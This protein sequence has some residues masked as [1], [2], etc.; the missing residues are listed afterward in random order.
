MENTY[1]LQYRINLA[2]VYGTFVSCPLSCID[3]TEGAVNIELTA[4]HQD[5]R[6]MLRQGT[7]RFEVFGILAKAA[8]DTLLEPNPTATEH[9]LEAMGAAIKQRAGMTSRD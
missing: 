4:G 2:G 7:A 5:Y 8:C 6:D 9:S 1:R 3:A